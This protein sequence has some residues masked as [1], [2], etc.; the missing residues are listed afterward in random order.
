LTNDPFAN[1]VPDNN[2]LGKIPLV[3]SISISIGRLVYDSGLF[4]V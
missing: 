1:P 2:L 3:P 4:R